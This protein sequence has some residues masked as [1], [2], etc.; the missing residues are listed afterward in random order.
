[1]LRLDFTSLDISTQNVSANLVFS[2]TDTSIEYTEND[3]NIINKFKEYM[4][5]NKDTKIINISSNFCNISN[6]L[7]D[8]EKKEI[9]KSNQGR[10]KQ[11]KIKTNRKIQGT[12]T[13][14]SSQTSFKI[15][16]TYQI[17]LKHGHNY[18]KYR[19]Y[20]QLN[21]NYLE[22]SK[23]VSVK[24]FRNGNIQIQ[25]SETNSLVDIKPAIKEVNKCFSYVLG[26]TVVD[27]NIHSPMRN[28]KFNILGSYNINIIQTQKYFI[29][30]IKARVP[31]NFT[32][33]KLYLLNQT[34]FD[35]VELNN[36]LFNSKDD[37]ID[38][39]SD[40][41]LSTIDNFNKI[42][43]SIDLKK[44]YIQYEMYK[45]KNLN[46]WA[47]TILNKIKYYYLKPFIDNIRDTLYY[48]KDN[49][50]SFVNGDFEK[51]SGLKIKFRSP[52]QENQDKETTVK[53]F[54]SGKI[55]INGAQTQDEA[56]R[57]YNYLINFF[58]HNSQ[59][60][61]IPGRDILDIGWDD[62]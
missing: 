36:Y 35:I 54:S 62:D 51:Y 25:G 24:V 10:K 27:K 49:C 60:I 21:D 32:N 43:L 40:I 33:L 34:E 2:D 48:S 56:S 58:K 26:E 59:L 6:P 38:L 18:D 4:D 28:Y 55:E 5:N 14:M 11:E 44:I 37:N 41:I 15:L 45:Q 22:V 61:Y 57:V 3:I 8:Q 52:T 20:K 16:S 19:D 31:I 47:I 17:K 12:G 42:I 29:N 1:M 9:K 53:I 13:S 39:E 23:P 46:N 30:Y 7:L 50:I